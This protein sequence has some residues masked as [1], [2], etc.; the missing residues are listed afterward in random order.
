Y[1]LAH[2]VHDERSLRAVPAAAHRPGDRKRNHH[3]FMPQSGPA[4]GPCRFPESGH[5]FEAEH[6][7]GKAQQHVAGS[8]VKRRVTKV[9]KKGTKRGQVTR[10][11]PKETDITDF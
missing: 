11:F 4:D 5:T 10:V 7:S 6:G 9:N 1:Q 8:S 3:L 2:A